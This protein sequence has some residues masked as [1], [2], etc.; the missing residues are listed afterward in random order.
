MSAGHSIV[1]MNTAR[2]LRA[3]GWSVREIVALLEREHGVRVH[4]N[5]VRTWVDERRYR[6]HR[7]VDA[8][9]KA[10]A[11]AAASG[12]RLRSNARSP[13]FVE[14]RVRALAD[15]GA[16]RSLIARLVEF[17]MGVPMTRDRVTT[18]L[19]REVAA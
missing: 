9:T 12:G 5:T 13:E 11:R 15:L 10:Q 1:V 2:K 18:I 7:A 14:A 17:D 16:S 8:L 3:G 4:P 6:R 19:N